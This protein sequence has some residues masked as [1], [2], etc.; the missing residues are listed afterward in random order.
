MC[1][2]DGIIWFPIPPQ[3][4]CFH[5]KGRDSE[6]R[7][8]R[9]SLRLHPLKS[10]YCLSR[11]L[12]FEPPL[13]FGLGYLPWGYI[14]LFATSTESVLAMASQ[15]HSLAVHGVL[16][17]FDGLLRSRPCGFVSPHCRVQG[18]PFR[19]SFFTH[20]RSTSSV[21]RAL[22]PLAT[23]ACRQFPACASSRCPVLRASLHA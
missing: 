3:S 6:H 14:A 20:R 12:L 1:S 23:F 19:G 9:L 22:S 17:A 18:S 11:V 21:S 10:L 16:H 4:R 2:A 8:P 13:P 15:G 7:S 5:R